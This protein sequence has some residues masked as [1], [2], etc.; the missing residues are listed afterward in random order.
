MRARRW[1][2]VVVCGIVG[3]VLAT[4]LVFREYDFGTS[5]PN[6]FPQDVPIVAGTITSCR[7]ARSDDLVRIV[8]VRI[9]SDLRFLDVVQFYRDAFDSRAT[10]HGNVPEFPLSGPDL[11]ETSS[12]ALFGRNTVVVII[13]ATGATTSVLVQVRGTSIFTLPR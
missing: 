9:Q 3:L 12:N 7:T 1:L 10:E 13:R 4:M 8:E 5:L 11:T 6:G 2:L